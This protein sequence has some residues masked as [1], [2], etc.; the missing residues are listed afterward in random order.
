MRNIPASEPST[1]CSPDSRRRTPKTRR[2]RAYFEP[3]NAKPVGNFG[4]TRALAGPITLARQASENRGCGRL[5]RFAALTGVVVWYLTL[6]YS[7]SDTRLDPVEIGVS[8]NIPRVT[9]PAR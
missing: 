9:I 5:E 7:T 6:L 8:S 4:Y 2:Y 3:D 1:C